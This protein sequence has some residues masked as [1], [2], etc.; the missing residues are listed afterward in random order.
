MQHA[1]TPDRRITVLGALWALAL[2]GWIVLLTIEWYLTGA[3]ACP[4]TPTSSLYGT[5][6][7]SW[8]PPGRTCTWEIPG[9]THTDG[10]PSARVGIAI[11]FVL[12]GASLLVLHRSRTGVS[13]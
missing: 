2:L 5:S 9:G 4:L 6:G 8:L 11:L 10:P 3:T 13:T 7:W 12:W 1:T